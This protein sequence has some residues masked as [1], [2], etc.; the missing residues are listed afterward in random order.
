MYITR[1]DDVGENDEMGTKSSVLCMLKKGGYPVQSGFV[2]SPEALEIFLTRNVLRDKL[3]DILASHGGSIHEMKKAMESI[4]VIFANAFMP[5]EV[6]KEISTAYADI[7][8]SDDVRAA[9]AALSMI[10]AGRTYDIV[11]VRC[12]AMRTGSSSYA[13][14]LDSFLNVTGEEDLI[15]HVKLCWASL[16]FPHTKKYQEKTGGVS[17]V[18]VIVQKMA[19]SEKSGIMMTGFGGD[20]TL[21][22]AS[23]GLGSA[24]TSG[25]VT[26]DEYLLDANGN[27]IEKNISK[28]MWMFERNEMTGA[29]ERYHVPGSRMD[30]QVVSESEMK[31]LFEVAR[32]ISTGN[33]QKIIDWCIGRNKISIN[34]VKDGNYEISPNHDEHS[35]EEVLVTGRF[36]SRGTATGSVLLA[37]DGS[38]GT[39]GAGSIAVSKNSDPKNVI[40]AINASAAITDE[41]SRLCNFG[42]LSREMNMPALSSTQNATHIL[43]E[44]DTV[45]IIA[46]Q[47]KVVKAVLAESTP[48]EDDNE[49]YSDF[50]QPAQETEEKDPFAPPSPPDINFPAMY[51]EANNPGESLPMPFENPLVETATGSEAVSVPRNVKIFAKTGPEMVGRVHNAEGSIIYNIPSEPDLLSSP[52]TSPGELWLSPN[53]EQSMQWAS[54]LARR[55]IENRTPAGILIPVVRGVEDVRSMRHQLPAGCIY[56]ISVKTPAMA[57]QNREIINE[58]TTLVNIDIDPLI[59]LSMGLKE[60]DENIHDAVL[61]FV[62]SVK[63]RCAETGSVCSVTLSQ[64]YITDWNIEM[65]V[66]QGVDVICVEPAVVDDVRRTLSRMSIQPARNTQESAEED[67]LP[68]DF[69]SPF[70]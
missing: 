45:K 2:I 50:S 16:F 36:V 35:H 54:D 52:A 23:W 24:I 18:S 1:L 46:D 10:K 25:I 11:A 60:P 8:V 43:K 6:R 19:P 37:E 42:I 63:G 17:S 59:Q 3:E 27:L 21:I 65:L 40:A 9:Q 30:A 38:M 12:A 22:E 53:N 33:S 61:E 67:V 44:G 70:S 58:D 4:R 32:S 62:K 48:S 47:G 57:F 34:D 31:K 15:R 5:E 14:V 68:I 20:K 41:G 7:S 66:K 28:K 13:G 26:P 69:S 55:F 56:G 49:M 29:T 64:K 51:E 39:F